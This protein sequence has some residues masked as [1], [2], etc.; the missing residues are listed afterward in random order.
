ML[1]N[2]AFL[3]SLIHNTTDVITI[4]KEDGTILFQSPSVERLFGYTENE[5]VG[6][7]AFLL[8]HPDDLPEVIDNLT[9]VINDPEHLLVTS[10][11]VKHKDGGW[12]IL[13]ST[14]SNQLENPLIR[15][16]VVNS[17]D[18]TERSLAE[19]AL[20]AREAQLSTLVES[21]PFELFGIGRDGRYFL[22]NE[23]C[24]KHW[25]D[26]IGKKPE[27]VA[28]DQHTL[29][30]W[31]D[32]NRR[33]FSGEIVKGEIELVIGDEK[34]YVYNIIS[35]ILSSG[36]VDG[37]VGF[38]IDITE[39]RHTEEELS[40]Y[41]EHLE[42][43][44]ARRAE[45]ISA[46]NKQ[47]LQSQKL[48]AI[49]VLAGGVAHEFSNIL[50]TMKGAAYLI[51]KKLPHDSPAMKYADQIVS[52]IAK[53]NSLS[54]ELLSFSRQRTISLKPVHFNEAIKKI[55]RLLCRLIGEHIELKLLLADS[56]ATVMADANQI[57][58]VLVNLTT[59]ARDAMP[60]GGTLT[61]K[62][63]V[64][65]M[66]EEF[67]KENGYGV[68]GPYIV[69]TVSDTGVGMKEQVRANIFQPFF[70]TKPVGKGSGL[71]LA[72]TYGI[73]KQHNG[74]IDVE[75]RPERGTT[76]RIYLP[77]VDVQAITGEQ[78]GDTLKVKSGEETILLAED[79][80]DALTMTTELLK[81]TGYTVLVARDGEEAVK[82][83]TANHNKVQLVIADVRMPKKDGQVVFEEIR[84][85]APA[86][87][88][89]FMSGYTADVIDSH[90]II[91][92]KD[93]EFISK[94][95]RPDEFLAKVRDVLD[96]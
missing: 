56:E 46:L 72:V 29:D 71:G 30:V 38:N 60:Y 25:G 16:I 47:L 8:I 68:A 80:S 26:F 64:M 14:G 86:A 32:N 21:L 89:L 23:V 82:V 20:R 95:A 88:F 75:S 6:T 42:E 7:D 3:S 11:R 2:A 65:E 45:E 27:E 58:Q 61:I 55:V 83:F 5:L 74:F 33:A 43:L 63:D 57:E 85:I 48:E 94:G 73:I 51:Q 13:E 70:T 79:D 54:Q 35:P 36:Q 22:Q 10:F 77:T 90:G 84:K 1:E 96:A 34:K 69:L 44:V 4:L 40:K 87:R 17:R 53:A 81:M 39:R 49:G 92:N 50:A 59:N 31:L 28:N 15:G 12:R 37:I 41:R 62:T 18:I 19:E 91:W 76:F 24:R 9:R 67:I 78:K 52:S 66:H 93:L